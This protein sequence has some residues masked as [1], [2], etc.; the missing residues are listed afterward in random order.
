MHWALVMGY[1]QSILVIEPQLSLVNLIGELNYVRIPLNNRTTRVIR[2]I[3]TG[4]R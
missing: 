2:R 3:G 4:T 1:T